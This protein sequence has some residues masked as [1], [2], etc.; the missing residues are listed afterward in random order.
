[1]TDK[2]TQALKTAWE[3]HVGDPVPLRFT[4]LLDQLTGGAKCPKES[5]ESS[6]STLKPS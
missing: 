1:M 6:S 3:A 5:R 2:I 4:E